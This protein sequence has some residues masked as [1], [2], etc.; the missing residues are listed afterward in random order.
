MHCRKIISELG[1]SCILF[2]STVFLSARF[3]SISSD[4]QQI[5]AVEVQTDRCPPHWLNGKKFQ[6]Y[7]KPVVPSCK[8]KQLAV[9][10]ISILSASRMGKYVKPAAL[11]DNS[12]DSSSL[13]TSTS[14]VQ[15]NCDDT[16]WHFSN[17]PL[18][19]GQ[20]TLAAST[21]Q[22]FK[23]PSSGKGLLCFTI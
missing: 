21:V 2:R 3:G 18:S 15:V 17:S 11:Y 16:D 8:S 14:P 5:K 19:S 1:L 12:A 23:N 7:F 9:S 22:S 20:S 13:I 6:V 10:L 4:I